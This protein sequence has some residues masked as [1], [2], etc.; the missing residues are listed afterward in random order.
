V[1]GWLT[2]P[3]MVSGTLKQLPDLERMLSRCHAGSSS[4]GDF[5]TMLD[6]FEQIIV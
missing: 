1:E 6:A 2:F 3:E 5:L 4:L